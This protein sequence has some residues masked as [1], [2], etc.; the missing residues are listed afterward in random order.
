MKE[1]RI[2]LIKS[3]NPQLAGGEKMN[4]QYEIQKILYD[5]FI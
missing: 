3:N 5:E 4:L 1:G 2:A